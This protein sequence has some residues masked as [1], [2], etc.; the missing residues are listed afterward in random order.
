MIL[1]TFV[2]RGG[3]RWAR[4]FATILSLAFV[5]TL[6][7]L[8]PV[9][10]APPAGDLDQCA[11]GGVSKPDLQCIDPAG[12]ANQWQN[13]NLN[14]QQAHYNEGQSVPYRLRLSNLIVGDS[15]T[16][17]IE[18]DTTQQGKHA[19]D[20]LTDYNRTET[21]A[22]PCSGVAGCNAAVFDTF[23]IP[24]DPNVSAGQDG[25]PGNGDDITQIPGVLTMFGGDM[26]AVSGYTVSGTYAG[27]SAT[28]ITITFTS[29]TT[30]P[31]LAW[32]G[33]IATRKDWGTGNSAVA[34][35]G[36]PYHMRMI[37][38]NGKSGNQDRSLSNDAVIFPAEVTIIK[39]VAGGSATDF[40][41]TSTGADSNP[42]G[43]AAGFSLDDDANA[44][45]PD[46]RTFLFDT[47]G[48]ANTRTVTETNPAPAFSLTGL[49]CVEDP[50]G[51]SQTDNST[52]NLG[53]RTATLLLEE[54]ELVTCTFTNTLQ[55]GTLTVIKSVTNDNGGTA[56]AANFTLFVKDATSAHVTGSPAAGSATGTVYTLVPATYTVGEN[57]PLPAGYTGPVFSGD[58]NSSGSVTVL[59]GQNVTCT[60]TNDDSKAT[61]SGT[62]VQSWV[63]KDSITISGIRAGAPDA[64]SASVTFRLYSNAACSTLVGS[65][66]D[67]SIV[68]GAA[69]TATGI[70]VSAT[71]FY[72]W[73]AQYSGDQYNNG[74]TTACGQE[75]SQIQAKDDLPRNNLIILP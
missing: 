38:I 42:A 47:F 61:P 45:L 62:T 22:L 1:S 7:I 29:N 4:P 51:L 8:S 13:G 48:A 11:N 72:Y 34:I 26:T 30:N 27:S 28:K 24:V 54:A 14:G 39:E 35:S 64:S 55:T 63:L 70:S 33:H 37:E 19:L 23:P 66:T 71:G 43:F 75:I 69:S 9:L 53:T 44:T 10:A 15:N 16:V 25:V 58:C 50:G 5:G 12:S 67:S 74:F 18:W 73:T 59:A 60:L 49:V 41:F 40:A 6:L 57:T 65:E 3:S 31:V 20:Y 52:T 17:T 36:S 2:N 32:G 21:D 46:R 56:T 68:A